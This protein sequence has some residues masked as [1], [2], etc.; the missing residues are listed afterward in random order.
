MIHRKANYY[1]LAAVLLSLTTTTLI[2]TVTGQCQPT[3]CDQKKTF[4]PIVDLDTY[5]STT[6]GLSGEYLRTALNTVIR[7]NHHKY[8]YKCIW[9]ALE[10]VDEDPNEPN[11]IRTI[12]TQVSVPKLN[13]VCPNNTN[14]NRDAWNREHVWAKSHGFPD[15]RQMAY[16]DIHHLVPA[17]ADQNSMRQD[18]DFQVFRV[19]GAMWEPVDA[20][21]GQIAR[22]MFYMEVRYDGNSTSTK[23]DADTTPN[24]KLVN[25]T[26]YGKR[27]PKF[28]N[29]TDLLKW[30]CDFPVSERELLRNDKVY[31]WQGNRNPFIDRPDFLNSIWNYKCDAS[32]SFGSS[33]NRLMEEKLEGE[34]KSD[35]TLNESVLEMSAPKS[36]L[37]RTAVIRANVKIWSLI[38]MIFSGLSKL[39]GKKEKEEL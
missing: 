27:M 20:V 38:K 5:Y 11:N 6:T 25:T 26:T 4:E 1:I 33:S 2:K 22:M 37:F 8:S 10:E 32:S 29:L 19:G 12:Y 16:T 35:S 7:A 17:N 39:F 31:T 34:D 14:S 21:K 3:S 30:H 28:G 13:R 15:E 23:T 18:R 36:N 9:A 24:L